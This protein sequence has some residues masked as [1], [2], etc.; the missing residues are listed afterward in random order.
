MVTFDVDAFVNDCLSGLREGA[1]AAAAVREVVDR[2]VSHPAALR[3]TL[4][5]LTTMPSMQTWY[6]SDA[7]TVLHLVWPPD[8]DLQPHDHGMWA[9]IGLYGGREDNHFYRRRDD[10]RI[11]P[12]GGWTLREGDVIGLGEDVVHRVANPSREWTGAI[13]VYGGEFFDT[14]RTRWSMDTFEP[15]AFDAAEVQRYLEEVAQRARERGLLDQV[16]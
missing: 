5:D 1:D 9:A 11:D 14:P 15:V 7:L 13:H 4:G 16:T 3:A 10:G 8:A 2:T 6:R 12:A